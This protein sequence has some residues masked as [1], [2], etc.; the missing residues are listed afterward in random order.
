MS[1][2]SNIYIAGGCY[3]GTEHFFKQVN[4]VIETRVGFANGN[5]DN[6]T[7]EQVCKDDTGFAET[8]KVTYDPQKAPLSFLLNLY[9]LTIDPTSV[10]K[11]GEDTGNQYRTGIYYTNPDDK[12]II[13]NEICQL[14]KK[15][16]K[17][18]VVEVLPLKNFVEA[19]EAH[20]DYLEKNPNGY[21]H[22]N[23]KLF[24]LA[25]EARPETF[26]KDMK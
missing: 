1:N 9:F 3:W 20:Q 16:D 8:V 2:Y 14:Q 6:P 19:H 24:K 17:P 13:D 25:R 15:Y 23:F 21:C 11:Q 10:N 5:I 22:V 7:Y 12:K 26:Q 18:I 4:G